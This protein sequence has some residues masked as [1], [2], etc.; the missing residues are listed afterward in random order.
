MTRAWRSSHVVSRIKVAELLTEKRKHDNGSSRESARS[1][2]LQC[3]NLAPSL[4]TQSHQWK[5]F[6]FQALVYS[7]G[8]RDSHS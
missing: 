1:I 6:S 2:P 4:I 7:L 8:Q 5:Y 3:P